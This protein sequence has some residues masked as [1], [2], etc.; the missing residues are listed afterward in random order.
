MSI[1]EISGGVFEVKSTN[2]D[3]MLGGEDFD[4]ELQHLLANSRKIVGRSLSDPLAMQRLREAAEKAKRVR[5]SEHDGRLYPSSRRA[6]GPKHL[7]VKLGR[8]RRS[9]AT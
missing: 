8:I 3:T 6:I 1:L 5:W 7:N 9:Q 4:E 2:G